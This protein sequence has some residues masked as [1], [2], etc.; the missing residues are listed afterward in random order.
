MPREDLPIKIPESFKGLDPDKSIEVYRRKLPHWRQENATYFVTFRQADA[1]PKTAINGLELE[2]KNYL[3]QLRQ[4]DL[5]PEARREI[6]ERF[7][8]RY[9]VLLDRYLD[10]G[11]G[12]CRLR[13]AENARLVIDALRFFD[14]NNPSLTENTAA[15]HYELYSAVVM[16]NHCHVLVRPIPG[17]DLE[18]ILQSWKSF[19]S[20]QLNKTAGVTGSFWQPDNF[21]RIVR[22]EAHYRKVIHYIRRNPEKAKL[23]PSGYQLWEW[24]KGIQ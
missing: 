6:H 22:D 2:K 1:L 15:P 24:D 13:T 10:A 23:P 3:S 7:H 5:K 14:R 16:P 4:S 9:G 21:D 8:K 18:K 11:T 17:H 20:R 12:S 19:T